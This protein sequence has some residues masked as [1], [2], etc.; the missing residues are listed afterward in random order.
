[1]IRRIDISSSIVAQVAGDVLQG[2]DDAQPGRFRRPA[3][4]TVDGA[5]RLLI[6]D[7]GNN[8]IRSID[9][10]GV[11]SLFAGTAPSGGIRPNN[12]GFEVG[13]VG[14]ARFQGPTALT[15]DSMGQLYVADTDNHAIRIVDGTG[16][17]STLA[18][19]GQPGADD[20]TGPGALFNEPHGLALD[21]AGHLLVADTGNGVIR[22][23]DLATKVVTT[24]PAHFDAPMALA[25][26]GDV[27]YV[28]D[29]STIL[30]YT[31]GDV[32]A[33]V[34]FGVPGSAGIV[35]GPAPG[36]LNAPSGIAALPNG[37]LL[38]VD[39]AENAVLIA[40]L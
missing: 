17:V 21:D 10:E 15:I 8:V 23:I 3:G 9:P 5:S 20:G 33:E 27:L 19:D 35:L 26:S 12:G 31:P 24:L 36:G 14:I 22:S 11:I 40:H 28:S 34:I 2:Y 39:S 25:R 16:M 38:I 13:P 30:R 37:D 6:A 1:L 29:G 4:L 7:T 18:G 32:M